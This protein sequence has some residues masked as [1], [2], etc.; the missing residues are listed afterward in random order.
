MTMSEP[1]YRGEGKITHAACGREEAWMPES[2]GN[3]FYWWC[4]LCKDWFVPARTSTF[5]PETVLKYDEVDAGDFQRFLREG[6]YRPMGIAPHEA[7]YVVWL[8][9]LENLW[10]AFPAPDGA[11]A[12]RDEKRARQAARA[13]SDSPKAKEVR[14]LRCAQEVVEI[15]K[16]G[17]SY[18]RFL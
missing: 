9:R 8:D 18:P 1:I 16:D 13:A 12:F 6:C 7:F 10:R 17:V 15:L 5:S 2:A 4:P 11:P 14:V 3:L